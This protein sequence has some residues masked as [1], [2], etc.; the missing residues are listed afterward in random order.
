MQKEF[1]AI[2]GSECKGNR[3]W[4]NC[5]IERQLLGDYLAWVKNEI[6]SR[7]NLGGIWEYG[8]A[9]IQRMLEIGERSNGHQLGF[10][11]GGDRILHRTM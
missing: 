10:L 6:E 3:A 5:D 2:G 4:L 11:E 9:P 1:E 8:K 7:P